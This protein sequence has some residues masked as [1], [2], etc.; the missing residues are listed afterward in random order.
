M[1]KYKFLLIITSFIF[2][3]GFKSNGAENKELNQMIKVTEKLL[4]NKNFEYIEKY[5]LKNNFKQIEIDYDNRMTGRVKVFEKNKINNIDENSDKRIELKKIYEA[6]KELKREYPIVHIFL[7][8]E[9][10][11]R[12]SMFF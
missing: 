9:A 7:V 6:T 3:V 1:G 11:K 8:D 12:K 2:I 5:A 4:K 10:G